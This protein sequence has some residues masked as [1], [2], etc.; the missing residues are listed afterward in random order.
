M[1]YLKSGIFVNG[2]KWRWQCNDG[3]G[4]GVMDMAKDW[5]SDGKKLGKL[6]MEMLVLPVM[7]QD[8]S[9]VKQLDLNLL[10]IFHWHL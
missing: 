4:N 7:L 9:P 8:T 5:V 6:G 3:H 1:C 10:Y 2:C